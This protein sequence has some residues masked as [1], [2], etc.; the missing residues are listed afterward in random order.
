VPPAWPSGGLGVAVV[1]V[2]PKGDIKR[3]VKQIS[4]DLGTSG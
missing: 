1:A 3:L 4:T 2:L